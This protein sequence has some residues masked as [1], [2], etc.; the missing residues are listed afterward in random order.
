MP[1]AIAVAS[2]LNTFTLIWLLTYVTDVSVIVQFLV[3]LVGLGVAIDYSLLM[4]FRFREELAGGEDVETAVVE[5][6]THAGRSVIV[7]GSTVAIGLLS[8]VIMPVPII[9]SIGIGGMLIP[10]VS[11]VAAITLL[12]ALLSLLG[13]ADQPLRVMPKRLVEGHGRRGA[14][15]GAAG[16]ASS[17]RR[18]LLSAARAS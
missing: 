5:T 18:P 15:S 7:S 6:M 17:M 11:V 9:R 4:I 2:I 14:A 8:M 10:A 16:R 12:P 1:L 13:H 3:A